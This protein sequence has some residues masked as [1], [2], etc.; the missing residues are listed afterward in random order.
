[1][2]QEAQQGA[3]QTALLNLEDRKMQQGLESPDKPDGIFAGSLYYICCSRNTNTLEHNAL[4]F[5]K[6]NT[7]K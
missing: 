6:Q 7:A 2:S 3:I 5:K 4:K 1:M